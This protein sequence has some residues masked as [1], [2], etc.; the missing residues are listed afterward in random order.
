[1]K[2]EKHIFFHAFKRTTELTKIS[3][4]VCSSINIKNCH[5]WRLLYL[6][7]SWLDSPNLKLVSFFSASEWRR[8]SIQF[9]FSGSRTRCGRDR[10]APWS[11]FVKTEKWRICRYWLKLERGDLILVILYENIQFCMFRGLSRIQ[12]YKPYKISLNLGPL[13]SWNWDRTILD[14]DPRGCF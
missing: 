9:D 3:V 5:F 2:G 7:H 1:M 12:L 11:F 6:L 8:L 4:Y 13:T 14:K 10:Q